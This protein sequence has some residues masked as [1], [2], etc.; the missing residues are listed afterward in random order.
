MADFEEAFDLDDVITS[1]V[2]N[3]KEDLKTF[4]D[5][6]NLDGSVNRECSG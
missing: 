6:V 1:M 5:L 4:E 3:V 2:D